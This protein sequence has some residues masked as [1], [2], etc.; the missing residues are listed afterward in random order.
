MCVRTFIP[1]CVRTHK[2]GTVHAMNDTSAWAALLRVH[3]AVVPL[4]DREL[5]TRCRLP[6]TWYDVLLE[7]S[8]APDRELTMGELGGR[9][10]VT[11]TRVSRIVVEL[12]QAGLVEKR[13]NPEDARSSIARI[14]PA[15]RERLRK[16]API[17]LAAIDRHFNAHLRPGESKAVATALQRVLEERRAIS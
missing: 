16:A 9:A 1:E 6:L 4:L 8:S 14:T 15:G 12:E 5:Q 10:V 2:R 3:A 17:Y 7:L 13:L 11:R